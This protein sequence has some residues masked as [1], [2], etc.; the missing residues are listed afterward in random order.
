VVACMSIVSL[1]LKP[2]ETYVQLAKRIGLVLIVMLHLKNSVDKEDGKVIR[3]LKE[4]AHMDLTGQ[5]T[6]RRCTSICIDHHTCII[7]DAQAY[8]FSIRIS[9]AQVG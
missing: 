3:I 4:K 8:Y 6:D 5:V 2:P 7:G 1:F 9:S